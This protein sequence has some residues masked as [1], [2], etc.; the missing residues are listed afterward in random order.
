M[1]KIQHGKTTKLLLIDGETLFNQGDTGNTA[2]MIVHGVM[3]VMV[4]GK[5]VGTMRDGEV[6]GEMALILNQRR[7]ASIISNQPTE[8]ISISKENLD[9]L[10]DSGSDK[11]KKII[12]ELCEELAKRTEFQNVIY[13][14]DDIDSILE[15]ENQIITKLT[16]QILYRL[17]R[18]TNHVE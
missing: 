11:A 17:E 16:K 15:S 1:K 4:D 6:F 7:S 9:E 12:I 14:H 18:S 13:T 8:L 10:I 5:K 2:Y 3:D